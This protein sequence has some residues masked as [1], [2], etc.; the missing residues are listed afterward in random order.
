MKYRNG[1]DLRELR[2]ATLS[3][4]V[5]YPPFRILLNCDSAHKA[6]FHVVI[7]ALHCVCCCIA[8]AFFGS[9]MFAR[10][11]R[12]EQ[13]YVVLRGTLYDRSHHLLNS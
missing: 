3:S 2:E 9:C 6:P 4:V 7:P 8:V 13:I 11:T 10:C 1:F 5:I 12:F